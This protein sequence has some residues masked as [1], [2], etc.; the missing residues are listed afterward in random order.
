MPALVAPP[1]EAR[2]DFE[3]FAALA[4]RL[5]VGEAF[6]EGLDRTGWLRRLWD[7][8]R[9]R[10]RAQGF[11]LPDFEELWSKGV[12]TV[13]RRRASRGCCSRRSGPIPRARR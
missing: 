1:G 13:P 7:D 4:A 3:V 5:G 9:R 2:D 11:D 10:A 6:T 12:V 8:A